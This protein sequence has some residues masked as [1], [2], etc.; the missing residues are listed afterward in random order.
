[1][2]TARRLAPNALSL[3]LRLQPDMSTYTTCS[4]CR[5]PAVVFMAPTLQV[6]TLAAGTEIRK[7]DLF[8]GCTTLARNQMIGISANAGSY[9]V[10]VSNFIC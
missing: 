9:G 2:V 1:M 7:A 3:G 6:G 5:M 4:T 10:P 8:L